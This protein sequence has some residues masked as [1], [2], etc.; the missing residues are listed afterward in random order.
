LSCCVNNNISLSLPS[1]STTKNKKNMEK[2]ICT[3]LLSVILSVCGYVCGQ[4]THFGYDADGNMKSAAATPPDLA[5]AAQPAQSLSSGI[6][7]PENSHNLRLRPNPFKDHIAITCDA[8]ITRV[9]IAK[10]GGTL[11]FDRTFDETEVVIST[12]DYAQGIYVL[13]ITAAQNKFT[14]IIIKD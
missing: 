4:T 2:M 6:I 10:V 14:R 11:V 9:E 12:A 3:V 5:L 1:I 13:Y 8:A 7:D